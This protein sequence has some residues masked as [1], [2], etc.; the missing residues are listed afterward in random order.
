M[1][2]GDCQM[3]AN[4]PDSAIDRKGGAM[5]TSSDLTTTWKGDRIQQEPADET[6]GYAQ[7]GITG[8]GRDA[9]EVILQVLWTW[10]GGKLSSQ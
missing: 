2:Q 7:T 10:I 6:N 4:G 1:T 9:D 5:G 3:V 8:A